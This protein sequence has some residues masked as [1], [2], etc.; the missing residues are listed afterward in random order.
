MIYSYHPPVTCSRSFP[1]HHRRPS[2][3]RTRLLKSAV[4][5]KRLALMTFMQ[6]IERGVDDSDTVVDLIDDNTPDA[7]PL[8]VTAPSRANTPSHSP[9]PPPERRSTTYAALASRRMSVPYAPVLDP[10]S[11][12]ACNASDAVDCQLIFTPAQG[13]PIIHPP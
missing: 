3:R 4:N 1:V 12:Y 9:V 6:N 11:P 7:G 13:H 5:H 8:N 10:H 2:K